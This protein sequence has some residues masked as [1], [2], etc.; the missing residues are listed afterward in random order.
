MSVK[1][2]VAEVK[3]V[4]EGSLLFAHVGK[5]AAGFPIQ[6]LCSDSA[7]GVVIASAGDRVRGCFLNYHC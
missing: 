7:M 2:I 4:A 3:A 5:F 6:F 1:D